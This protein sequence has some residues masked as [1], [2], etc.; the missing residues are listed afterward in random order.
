M[1]LLVLAACT[2]LAL[3][4]CKRTEA[5]APAATPAAATP[6]QAPAPAAAASA[7][8]PHDNLNA[9]A[10]VQ[11]SVEY[12]ALSEQ[13]Y[14]AAA[15]HLDQ[16]LKE[17][18]WDALVPEERGN[19]ATGLKPAVVM[20][21]DE[22]VLDNSPYQ[23]RLVRD[24]ADSDEVS[25]AQWVAEKKAKPVPGVVD[26]ARA[27]TAKGVTVLY[28]SNRAVHLE[29]AT[30]ANLKAVGLP[31]DEGVFLGL[32]TVVE[33]CEQNGSEKNCR[34]KLAGQKYRVLMQFGDQ[35]GDFVQVVANTREGR[36]QLYGEYHDWF[37][38]RW[39]MLPNPTYGSWEPA[40]F[41]NDWAQPR[42][43]RRQAKR[44]ALDY[45]P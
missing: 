38:E 36:D 31:V 35:I 15:D 14:R 20:D 2:A 21:V 17:K 6:S 45:A 4:A 26:F 42:E 11:T 9:V 1:R 19:A 29:Q 39:W 43:A 32:G 5:P 3:S 34:R 28:I 27:A 22:T 25:W 30:L 12:R 24:G 18:H 10:W 13:T 8:P 37:G 44:E 40:L 41:N 7:N 16:A 33:G 23:A